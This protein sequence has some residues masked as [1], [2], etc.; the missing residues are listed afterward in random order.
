M[1]KFSAKHQ[2]RVPQDHE[3]FKSPG[4]KEGAISASELRRRLGLAK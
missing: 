1:T 3:P 2:S 4:K